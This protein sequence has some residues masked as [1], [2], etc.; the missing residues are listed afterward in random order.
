[1]WLA[2]IECKMHPGFYTWV[3]KKNGEYLNNLILIT[4]WNHNILDMLSL[5]KYI[6]KMS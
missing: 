4:Y 6:I 3:R 5:V 1:M 2:Q